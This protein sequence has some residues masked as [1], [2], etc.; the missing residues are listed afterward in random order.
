M[1]KFELD[2]LVWYLK[3]NRVHSAK[4]LTRMIVEN[5]FE[6]NGDD[7][8]FR[9]FGKSRVVYGTIHGDYYEN[10]IFDSRESLANSLLE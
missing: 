3:D 2:Q 8:A 9:R 6:D 4:I 1:F 10:E 5:K 7:N